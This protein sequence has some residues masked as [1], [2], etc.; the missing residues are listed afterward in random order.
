M[1]VVN[2]TNKPSPGLGAGIALAGGIGQGL[3]D[4]QGENSSGSGSSTTNTSGE[5]TSNQTTSSD[6]N[7]ILQSLL[8]YLNSTTGHGTTTSTPN[9]PPEAQQMLQRLVGQYQS[10]SP[11]NSQAYQAGQIQGI[12]RNS[13]L[14]TQ[15]VEQNMAA[16][17][18]SGPAAATAV[19]NIGN[20]R[21]AQ[22]Q[23]MQQ[24][25][26]FLK[27]QFDMQNLMAGANLFNMIPHGSTTTSDTQQDTTGQQI[28]QQTSQTSNVA[29]SDA[30][31]SQ[32]QSQHT[33]KVEQQK[34]GG[35]VV[36]GIAGGLGGIASIAASLF[37]DERLKEDIQPLKSEGVIDKLMSL[38]PSSWKWG[39]TG[40]GDAGVIAQ[41]LLE[42]LPELVKKDDPSGF[43][44]VNYA[45]L[46]SYIVSA[47]QELNKRVQEA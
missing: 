23:Q 3:L 12:N 13:D 45:G 37:S 35:G 39:A 20:Q 31:S 36:R 6:T 26:P 17:G 28:G 16:R 21:F 44:K 41:D 7:S 22:I 38:R 43:L 19:N 25:M 5:S 33:D 9:L 46:T 30:Y 8:Q 10:F 18:V 15:S 14:Q 29:K 24:N 32:Q 1:G 40:E 47:M 11:F 34:S 42:V 27:N 4:S 2:N